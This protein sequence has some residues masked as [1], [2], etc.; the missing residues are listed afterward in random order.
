MTQH[1]LGKE[2]A[3][4]KNRHQVTEGCRRIRDASEAGGVLGPQPVQIMQRLI[5]VG[6]RSQEDLNA[7]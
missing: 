3:V 5:R 1:A 4:G 2:L 6:N 7:G